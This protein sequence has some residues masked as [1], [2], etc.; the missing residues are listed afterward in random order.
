MPKP[1][2]GIVVG[3]VRPN[4]FA[5]H[6][7]KWIAEI[8]RSHPELEFEIVDLK[9]YPLPLFNEVA[10]SLYVPSTSEVAQK[11][12]RKIDSLD[13][14][15][16]TAAEYSRGPTAALKNALDYA[17]TEWNRKPAAFVGY[18]GVGGARAIEQLRLH[19]IELQMVPI[20]NAV[21]IVWAD[22]FQVMQ[23]EKKL[24]EFEHLNAA[25]QTMLNE[26]SWWAKLLKKA[27]EDDA[28]TAQAA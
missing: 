24:E 10:S 14:F 5:D 3:S 16:F 12:Q 6:P 27:R 2:I 7:T 18:G 19:A 22:M 8:A 26:F 17:Y 25:A 4:R 21:H 13:G 1:K 11:W 15:I 23:G 20:R 9:D 28:R